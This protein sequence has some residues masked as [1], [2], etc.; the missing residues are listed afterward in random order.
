MLSLRSLSFALTLLLL[1]ACATKAQSVSSTSSVTIN[2]QVSGTV[3]LN[4]SPT[5]QLSDGATLVTSHKTDAHTLVVSI[6]IDDHRARQIVIPVQIRSN[7][8]YALSASIKQRGATPPTLQLLRGI[9]V[10]G[11]RPT[12]R[13]VA[14]DAFEAM[15]VAAFDTANEASRLPQASRNALYYSPVTLLAGPRISLA[16]M[17]D[18]PHNALEVT[19]VAEVGAFAEEEMQS[20]ELTL[21]ATPNVASSSPT[22]AQK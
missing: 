4:I 5:A 7:V 6:K 15:N 17:S 8:S 1:L 14:L 3:L 11:A 18:S 22:L 9:K 13:F 12:G 21:S 10:T 19:I 16:G 2:G 20:I